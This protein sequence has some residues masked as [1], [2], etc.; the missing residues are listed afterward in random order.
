MSIASEITRL[1]GAKADLAT[2]IEGKGVTVPSA[3]KLDGYADLVDAISQGGGGGTMQSKSVSYTPSTSAQSQTVTADAGYDGLS[4]VAVSVAAMPSGT[5]GTPVA[6]KGAVSS[7]SVTIT[8]SVTN[9]AGYIEGGTKTGTAVTVSASELVAGYQIKTANGTYDVTNLAS[10]I[11]NVQNTYSASDE[12][13]VVSNGALVAQTAHADVTPTTTDQTIDTTTNNSLKVIG[14]ADLV[15]GNIKKDIV[16]FGVTGTYEGSGGDP[17]ETFNKL[18]SN[19]LTSISS[20]YSGVLKG[21]TFYGSTNLL[22][23]DFPNVTD[24]K[25]FAFYNCSNM[26]SL[27][28]PKCTYVRGSAIRSTKIPY[29]VI[30]VECGFEAQCIYGNSLLIGLDIYG[31]SAGATFEGGACSDNSGLNTLVIR[32]PSHVAQLNNINALSNTPFAS[33]K[34]GGTLYVPA[35]MISSYQGASNWS[36]ILGY[37]TN[38]IKSIES[39]ATDPTAPVDLT[40]HYID[41][42]LI[43]T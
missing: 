38:Q 43:P 31:R 3:T 13:K 39:T 14:D 30:P 37:A 29:L 41:G 23:A 4:S 17:D 8:P 2:A 33:G 18:I 27:K 42:T 24:L 21:G 7:N 20:D 5:E 15:A 19:A 26:A 40:T 25:N 28:I 9:S 22:S 35:S 10:I 16:I 6:T 1:Q 11:V 36:T 12:G 34:A 32:H